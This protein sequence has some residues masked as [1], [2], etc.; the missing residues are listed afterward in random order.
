VHHIIINLHPYEVH[1]DSRSP[2]L[3]T[4]DKLTEPTA[5][6]LLDGTVE[7]VEVKV[8]PSQKVCHSVSVQDRYVVVQPTYVWANA[9]QYPL[10]IPID[11]GE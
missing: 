5:C 8:F 11:G 4:I 9:S 6:C 2:M 1:S 7:L 10:P 3:D